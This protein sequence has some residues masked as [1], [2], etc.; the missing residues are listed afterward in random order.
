MRERDSRERERDK[1]EKETL[2]VCPS[3][4]FLCTLKMCIKKSE[5]KKAETE[6]MPRISQKYFTL[7]LYCI[8]KMR[9]RAKQRERETES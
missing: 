7:Y 6:K 3:T 1:R 9:L 5:W 4:E 8:A 2:D